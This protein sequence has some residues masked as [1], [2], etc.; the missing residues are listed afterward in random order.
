MLSA[1]PAR[2]FGLLSVFTLVVHALPIDIGGT[3]DCKTNT[4]DCFGNNIYHCNGMDTGTWSQPA[5]KMCPSD[6]T[7]STYVWEYGKYYEAA[8]SKPQQQGA[9]CVPNNSGFDAPAEACDPNTT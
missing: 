8:P 3:C 6:T 1:I 5:Y 7:C 2:L 4:F 9:T